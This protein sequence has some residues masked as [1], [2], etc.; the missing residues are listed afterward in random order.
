M[1]FP[2]FRTPLQKEWDKLIKQ[3]ASF[4]SKK[5]QKQQSKL[6]ALLESK[7]PENLQSTLDKAFAKAFGL[8]FEK[9]TGV[10]EKTYSKDK[11]EEKFAVNS[12]LAAKKKPSR[13][14]LKNFDKEAGKSSGLNLAVSTAAGVGLGVLGIGI[15]DIVLFVSLQLKSLYQIAASYGKNYRFDEERKFILLLIQGAVTFGEEQRAIDEEIDFYIENNEF[16]KEKTLEQL[17]A[18]TSKCLSAEL[19]YMKFLQGVPI[20]GAVGGAY[21]FVYM[22]QINTYA[23]LKY[24]K[25]FLT[26]KMCGL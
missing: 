7:V 18:E 8:V 21:D 2:K 5:A 20:V 12:I 1:Q 13:K 23:K 9:G 10:I 6:N 17:I 14:S 22:N 24:Y 16:R 11:A 26:D 15:P 19:L 4:L 3:E 25:R